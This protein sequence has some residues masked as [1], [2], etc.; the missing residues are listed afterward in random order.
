MGSS[1]SYGVYWNCD[2]LYLVN[3][4][5]LM[6][7]LSFIIYIQ[8]FKKFSI[9]KSLEWNLKENPNPKTICSLRRE[10][11]LEDKVWEL[12]CKNENAF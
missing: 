6:D 2:D 11:V 5:L 7:M 12:I 1:L 9:S 4:Y 8:K 10:H 3:A